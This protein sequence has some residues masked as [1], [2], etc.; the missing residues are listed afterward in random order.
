MLRGYPGPQ[1]PDIAAISGIWGPKVPTVKGSN[2]LNEHFSGS[3]RQHDSV[4]ND[5]T[6]WHRRQPLYPTG[7]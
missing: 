3:F 6:I 4:A 5:Y 1:I 7:L 2:S